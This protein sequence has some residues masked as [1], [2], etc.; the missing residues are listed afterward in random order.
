MACNHGLRSNTAVSKHNCTV[1]TFVV[2]YGS[3]HIHFSWS[4]SIFCHLLQSNCIIKIEI[5]FQLGDFISYPNSQTLKLLLLTLFFCSI[6]NS[7]IESMS[8]VKE[9]LLRYKMMRVWIF[10]CNCR[11]IKKKYILTG[12]WLGYWIRKTYEN[13]LKLLWNIVY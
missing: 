9:N 13:R 8:F 3:N 4:G 12:S 2:E 7:I 5:L 10:C 11:V 6:C 1:H